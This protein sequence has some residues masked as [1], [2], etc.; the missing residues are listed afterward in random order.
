MSR[1][2]SAQAGIKPGLGTNLVGFWRL[3]EIHR[4]ISEGSYPNCSSLAKRFEVHPRT[5]ERDIERL[6]DLF[7]APVAYDPIRRG[8]YYTE[9]FS[10]PAMRLKEGEAIALFLGQKILLQ[11]KG[12]PFEQFVRQAMQKIRVFLPHE[13]EINLERMVGAVS[14]HVE[15]LRGEEVRV[16]EIYQALVQAIEERRTVEVNYFTA[17]RGVTTRRRIDPYHLRFVD[18][19]WYCIGYCHSRS[20]VR[21]FALDRMSALTV[22]QDRFEYPADFSLEEYLADAWVIERGVPRNVVIQ[23]DTQE[24]PYIRGRQWHPSQ[25]LEELPDGSLRMTLVIGGL[26]ELKR[27]IMSFGPHAVVIDPEELR[28]EIVSDLRRAL[29]QY[30]GMVAPSVRVAEGREGRSDT[31]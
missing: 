24:A 22:T 9:P 26:G 13:V 6:R 27:W 21:T 10:L 18:G 29:E 19:A 25:K 30:E 7:A 3:C 31:A 11:C 16:A 20:S 12:T 15:P 8:Y 14:F 2:S 23:F 1:S 4:L 28:A 17:S 5:V